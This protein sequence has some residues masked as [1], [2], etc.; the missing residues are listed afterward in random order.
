M[1]FPETCDRCGASLKLIEITIFIAS[2]RRP[3][4]L[5]RTAA[6]AI[7]SVSASETEA[8]TAATPSPE[9]VRIAI[10]NSRVRGG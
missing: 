7:A 4:V 2:S 8:Q 1:R 5:P 10:A 3:Y 9:I 6:T